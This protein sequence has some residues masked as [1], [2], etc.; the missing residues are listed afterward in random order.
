LDTEFKLEVIKPDLLKRA[1]SFFTRIAQHAKPHEGWPLLSL[2]EWVIDFLIKPL[3]LIHSAGVL[4]PQAEEA[5]MLACDVL[6]HSEKVGREVP[7]YRQSLADLLAQLP[8]EEASKRLTM[9]LVEL[10]RKP[11]SE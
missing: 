11:D 3:G 7:C 8:Q 10:P 1:L 2:D 5:I 6:E 9:S 4:R